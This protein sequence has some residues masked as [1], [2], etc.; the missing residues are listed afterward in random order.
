MCCRGNDGCL[1][2]GSREGRILMDSI[3][4]EVA[5]VLGVRLGEPFNIVSCGDY[6]E[7]A[8]FRIDGHGLS[9]TTKTGNKSL[10]AL[11]KGLLRGYYQAQPIED[12]VNLE[13]YRLCYVGD[14][15][16]YFTD[17]IEQAH[18]DD[19]DDRP[20]QDNSSRPYDKYVRKVISYEPQWTVR[21][22]SDS[23]VRYCVYEINQGA[24]PWLF[25]E[26]A[27]GLM[28]GTSYPDTITWLR[29]AGVRWGELHW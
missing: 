4:S 8:P 9:A 17:N 28:G 18:G 11:F 16:L 5:R 24:V 19:W 10:D 27:G 23:G 22:A 1:V 13:Y 21:E 3:M 6:F 15:L 29:K 14:S 20:Y 12:N 26:K 25:H 2:H 7:G